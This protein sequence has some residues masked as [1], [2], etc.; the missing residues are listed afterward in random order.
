MTYV[1]RGRERGSP[2]VV[3]GL[4]RESDSGKAFTHAHM[5][6]PQSKGRPCCFPLLQQNGANA[7]SK[8][9]CRSE[10]PGTARNVFG[11]LKSVSSVLLCWQMLKRLSLPS[12]DN[13]VISLYLKMPCNQFLFRDAFH[14][15]A[16]SSLSPPGA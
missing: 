15:I 10:M 3:L 9:S 8:D 7:R 11:C 13:A 6:A 5:R 14:K 4:P 2:C 1:V 12:T 16:H